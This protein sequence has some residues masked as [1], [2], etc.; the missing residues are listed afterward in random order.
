MVLREC[1]NP[2]KPR[3]NNYLC[4]YVTTTLPVSDA[5]DFIFGFSVIFSVNRNYFLKQC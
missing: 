4:T 3:G 1:L 2:L 5:A